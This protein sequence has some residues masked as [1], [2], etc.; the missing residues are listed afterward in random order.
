MKVGDSFQVTRTQYF[1]KTKPLP[2]TRLFNVMKITRTGIV[3]ATAH[4]LRFKPGVAPVV[5]PDVLASFRQNADGTLRD[6]K[7]AK[8]GVIPTTWIFHQW[9]KDDEPST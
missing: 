5:L 8:K 1:A 7:P 4:K 9:R 3:R 6:I 2:C